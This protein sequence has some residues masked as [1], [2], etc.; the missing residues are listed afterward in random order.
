MPPQRS[1]ARLFPEHSY[2]RI[3]RRHHGRS[4][5]DSRCRHAYLQ[6]VFTPTDTT[7]FNTASATVQIVVGTTGSTGI[8]GSPLFSSG[9]CCFFSQPTPYAITV[10]G[11]TAA[12]TGTVTVVFNGQTLGTGTLVPGSGATSSATVDVNSIYF[13]PGTTP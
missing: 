5:S 10:T 8:S 11:S 2:Y 4:R 1:R 7:D 12:P 9:D 3:P 13:V 6:V